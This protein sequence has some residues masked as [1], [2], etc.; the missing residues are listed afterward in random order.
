MTIP[1]DIQ[2]IAKKLHEITQQ[3]QRLLTPTSSMTLAP[4]NTS[5]SSLKG[6]M[7]MYWKQYGLYVVVAVY[8]FITVYLLRSKWLYRYDD[9]KQKKVFLWKRYIT[10]SV[11]LY[12]ILIGLYWIWNQ[13]MTEL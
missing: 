12:I 8:I 1:P 10:V 3:D 9:D 13:Y 4:S 7:G 2:E 6:R 11:V 5:S